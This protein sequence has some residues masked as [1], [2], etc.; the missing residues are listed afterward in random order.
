[1]ESSGAVV[2][3]QEVSSFPAAVAGVVIGGP[4]GSPGAPVRLPAPLFSILGFGRCQKSLDLLREIQKVISEHLHA[5]G[6]SRVL[7]P[8]WGPGRAPYV[9]T[10]IPVW[11]HRDMTADMRGT[12]G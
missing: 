6:I 9:T 1:M 5:P 4:A 12:Y 11:V 7:E 8:L 2:A 3:A 10:E